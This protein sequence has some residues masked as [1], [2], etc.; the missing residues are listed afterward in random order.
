MMKVAQNL[1]DPQDPVTRKGEE[2]KTSNLN[3]P[4]H[5]QSIP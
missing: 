1:Y 3:D 2:R 5:V 4:F